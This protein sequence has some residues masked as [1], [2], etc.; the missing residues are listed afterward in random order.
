LKAV[1]DAG[2]DL[3][4]EKTGVTPGAFTIMIERF[5]SSVPALPAARGPDAAPGG[6]PPGASGSGTSTPLI[7]IERFADSP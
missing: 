6:T 2:D 7:A 3:S 1:N 4:R 5:A